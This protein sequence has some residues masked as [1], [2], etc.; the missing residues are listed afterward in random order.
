MM[1]M[2]RKVENKIPYIPLVR[3]DFDSWLSVT[4]REVSADRKGD[5]LVV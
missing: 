5:M 3:G 1:I 4:R 2:G